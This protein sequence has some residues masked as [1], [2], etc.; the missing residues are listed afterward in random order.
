[1]QW[2]LFNA[3]ILKERQKIYIYVRIYINFVIYY[4]CKFKLFNCSVN[5][6]YK[7]CVNRKAF[8]ASNTCILTEKLQIQ[9]FVNNGE[10]ILWKMAFPQSHQQELIELAEITGISAVPGVFR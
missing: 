6:Y 10:I 3:V 5:L 8:Y 2:S 9:K 1:M 4:E 7:L